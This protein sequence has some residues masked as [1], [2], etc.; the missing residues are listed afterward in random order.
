MIKD[1]KQRNTDLKSGSDRGRGRREWNGQ[2]FRQGGQERDFE[3]RHTWVSVSHVSTWK[4]SLWAEAAARAEAL[5]WGHAGQLR[6][7]GQADVGTR[8]GEMRSQSRG[9]LVDQAH[10]GL[11]FMPSGRGSYRMVWSEDDLIW[12]FEASLWLL[13]GQ[14]R[15]HWALA[16]GRAM[17]DDHGSSG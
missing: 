3:G 17:G 16:E 2:H 15:R 14:R 5:W 1:N 12:V 6:E 8:V 11:D 13:I 7:T 10:G 9:S 4:K